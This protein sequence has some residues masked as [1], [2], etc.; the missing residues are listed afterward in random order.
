MTNNNN[1]TIYTALF[2]FHGLVETIEMTSSNPFF[3]SKY[4]S[5]PDIQRA[6]A[7][8]LRDTGLILVHQLGEHDTMTTSIVHV[9][10]GEKIEST[11]SLHIKGDDSQAWGSAITYAKRYAIGA[12]LN[13]CI[14]KDDDGNASSGRVKKGSKPQ[15][16]M[17]S[18]AFLK[19]RQWYKEGKGTLSQIKQ[20]Y[21]LTS[22]VEK[23]II[24]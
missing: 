20:K 19:A 11:F 12:L 23:A 18:D 13:L 10:T 21:A 8:P 6:I 24:S 4:A 15:L 14:D 5:L 3:K 7:G 2:H 16:K 9:S 17:N 1:N 22:D